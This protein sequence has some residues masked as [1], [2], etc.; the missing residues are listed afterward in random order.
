MS[1]DKWKWLEDLCGS[2]D[3]PVDM[4]ENHNAAS[5]ASDLA[6]AKQLIGEMTLALRNVIGYA[7]AYCRGVE[8]F[9][10]DAARA[11]HAIHIAA[12]RKALGIFAPE[13]GDGS[14]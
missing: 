13:T 7:E 6:N 3:G 2:V 9:V 4:A 12:A 8:T 11:R 10:D 14:I 1:A 5:M